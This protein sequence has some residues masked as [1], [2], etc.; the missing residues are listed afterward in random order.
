MRC[1]GKIFSF[2]DPV[3]FFLGTIQYFF[4]RGFSCLKIL[5]IE[6]VCIPKALELIDSLIP[7]RAGR[8][9]EGSPAVDSTALRENAHKL[10]GI[11]RGRAGASG[12]C[13]ESSAL[14]S[15]NL[16]DPLSVLP[17]GIYGVGKAALHPPAL[18]ILSHTPD[19]A[20]QTIAWVGKGIVYDT[21]GLSIKGKVR[22]RG[23]PGRGPGLGGLWM[24]H[25]LSAAWRKAASFPAPCGWGVPL[26][27]GV[28]GERQ[29]A[30][31]P[32][33]GDHFMPI[34]QTGVWE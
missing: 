15:L 13:W 16:M 20:T 18:A 33:E 22:C 10:A 3:C 28:R 4:L 9:G 31:S 5:H 26:G 24:H 2:C 14:F 27:S 32:P 23:H 6:F 21:G 17:T 1:Y 7:H 12:G 19:G 34:L 25:Q 30:D 29:W 8:R 11:S